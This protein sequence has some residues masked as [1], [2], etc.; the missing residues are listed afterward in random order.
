MEE[1]PDSSIHIY[2]RECAEHIN[3]VFRQPLGV[4][5][6]QILFCCRFHMLNEHI[7][8][9]D[10]VVIGNWL[11]ARFHSGPIFQF[12]FGEFPK[13]I[14]GPGLKLGECRGDCD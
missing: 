4:V 5:A 2:K 7:H 14:L 6:Q 12:G 1:M 9:I 13:R 3:L 8:R 11:A 10:G